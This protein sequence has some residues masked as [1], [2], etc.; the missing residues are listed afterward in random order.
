MSVYYFDLRDGDGLVVDEVGLELH[1]TGAAQHEAAR[2]LAGFAWDAA[3]RYDGPG[4][5]MAIEVRDTRR[6]VWK[7]NS[8]SRLS[9]A[10]DPPEIGPKADGRS[11][12]VGGWDG[13]YDDSRLCLP[14][15]DAANP[16]AHPTT[17]VGSRKNTSAALRMCSY[18]W[19]GRAAAK[20][21][22]TRKLR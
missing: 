8:P 14:H 5:Q 11:M 12:D 9:A 6:P 18:R 16:N 17:S 7:S 22:S 3:R 19:L 4:H 13:R 10:V 2:T 21:S 1:D 15:G 20:T